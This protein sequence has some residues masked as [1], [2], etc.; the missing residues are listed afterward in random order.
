M[1][2]DALFC[3]GAPASLPGFRIWVCTMGTTVVGLVTPHLL[4]VVDLAHEA[5]K[6]VNVRFHLQDAVARSMAE[7]ADQF[8]AS[9]LAAA[10]VEGLENAAGRAPRAQTDYVGVLQTAADT[11][12]R[13]G[14]V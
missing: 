1:C 5:Q 11:A 9:T 8:N 2:A 3:D 12:R 10:Y 6:G 13:L 14:R 7:L 4:R